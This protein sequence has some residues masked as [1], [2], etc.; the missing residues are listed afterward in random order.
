[1][2]GAGWDRV[3]WDGVDRE[4]VKGRAGLDRCVTPVQAFEGCRSRA[5]GGTGGVE[6][7]HGDDRSGDERARRRFGSNLHTM[8]DDERNREM[9]HLSHL[10]SRCIVAPLAIAVFG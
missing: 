4:G 7:V 2:G 5:E 9:S 1:M 10:I 6:G 8:S 3:R